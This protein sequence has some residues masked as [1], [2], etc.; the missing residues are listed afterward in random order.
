MSAAEY[1]LLA[2]VQSILHDTSL[3]DPGEIADKV[4]ESVPSKALRKCLRVTLRQYVAAVIRQERDTTNPGSSHETA[5]TQSASAAAGSSW[6]RNGIR[7]GWRHHLTDRYAVAGE[8]MSLAEMTADHLV[9]A[10]LEREQLAAAN[11]ARGAR[12]R[13]WAR[14]LNE[15]KATTFG[16]L[17]A[18]VQA[19]VLS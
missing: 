12:L 11:I 1:S 6:K 18:D 3:S 5:D 2:D 7:D 4:A 13:D 9:A 10:A 8:W 19:R 14:L 16:D 15:H 17:P